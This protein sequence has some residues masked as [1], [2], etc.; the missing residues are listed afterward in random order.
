[1]RKGKCKCDYI[2]E[3]SHELFAAYKDALGT[4]G[5]SREVFRRVAMSACSRFWVS[6]ERAAV[7]V[8]RMLRGRDIGHMGR[9]RRAMFEELHRRVALRRAASPEKSITELVREAVHSP[10]PCFYL[11]A[12]T[13]SVLISKIKRQCYLRTMQ[14]LRHC[15]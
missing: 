7:V 2:E 14:R 1:M 11:T 4:Q 9:M 6:E 5:G 3:R 8:A 10:A 13:V 15:L 12:T